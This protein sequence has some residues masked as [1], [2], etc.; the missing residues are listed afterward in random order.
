MEVHMR[1][2]GKSIFMAKLSI[3][4]LLKGVSDRTGDREKDM[5]ALRKQP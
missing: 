1:I 4:V 2:K 3:I 5:P